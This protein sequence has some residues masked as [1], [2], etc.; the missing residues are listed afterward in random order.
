MSLYEYHEAPLTRL[1]RAT[2]AGYSLAYYQTNVDW[3][4]KL[5]RIEVRVNRPGLTLHYRRGYRATEEPPQR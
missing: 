5:R 2:A 1:L 3:N 4:G